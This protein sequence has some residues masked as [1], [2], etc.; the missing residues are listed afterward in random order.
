MGSL[1]SDYVARAVISDVILRVQGQ[2]VSFPLWKMCH[3]RR[4]H[5][6]DGDAVV[7][8]TGKMPLLL[9]G[10]EGGSVN[11]TTKERHN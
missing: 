3:P 7:V 11:A 6:L 10:T 5:L 4:L 1:F 8:L 9:G 2:R